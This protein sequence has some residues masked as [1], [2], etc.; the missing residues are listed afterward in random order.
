MIN[1]P[2]IVISIKY[3]YKGSIIIQFST[4]DFILSFYFSKFLHSS[5]SV[6]HKIFFLSNVGKQSHIVAS[7]LLSLT[8]NPSR[9]PLN[10]A[11]LN[12]IQE[13]QFCT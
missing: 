5:T 9:D 10:V 3:L 13:E 2:I 4:N 8:L 6:P 1:S 7:I 12:F 11:H